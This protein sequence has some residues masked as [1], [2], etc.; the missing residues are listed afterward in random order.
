MSG[1]EPTCQVMGRTRGIPLAARPLLSDTTQTTRRIAAQRS[2]FMIFGTDASWM[3]DLVDRPD[4]PI[5]ILRIRTAA[6][7]NIRY[8]LR[9]AGVTESVIF[10]DLDGLG[11]ELSQV[12]EDRR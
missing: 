11:R 2:R 5:Q 8:E 4:A 3:S 7:P 6:I 1:I 9:D 10:P 12:W